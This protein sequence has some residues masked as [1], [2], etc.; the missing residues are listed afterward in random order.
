MCM[1]GL[2]GGKHSAKKFSG[3]SCGRR[4]A[5]GLRWTLCGTIGGLVARAFTGLVGVDGVA[6]GAVGLLWGSRQS[7]RQS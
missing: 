7:S 4:S 2:E 6:S 3:D 1:D 5:A